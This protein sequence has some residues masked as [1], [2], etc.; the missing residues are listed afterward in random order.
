MG[1]HPQDF[2]L[3]ALTV[4]EVEFDTPLIMFAFK[5]TPRN[6]NTLRLFQSPLLKGEF[7]KLIICLNPFSW[8]RPN[9]KA[10]SIPMF[11]TCYHINPWKT[12]LKYFVPFMSYC[13]LFL[14]FEKLESLCFR[15]SMDTSS[16]LKVIDGRAPLG[17][18]CAA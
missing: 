5:I 7:H 3:K 9:T 18:D 14:N 13:K 1:N 16:K 12:C 2:R 17:M 11:W 6:S 4:R 10:T 15:G 8:T